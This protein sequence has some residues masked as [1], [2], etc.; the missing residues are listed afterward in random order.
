M[1]FKLIDSKRQVELPTARHDKSLI[2]SYLAES[3]ELKL[4]TESVGLLERFVVL[5]SQSGTMWVRLLYGAAVRLH[6]APYPDG[7]G[8]MIPSSPPHFAISLL[9]NGFFNLG[10]L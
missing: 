10:C 3:T 2:Y 7:F 1:G 4:N 5:M 9:Y 8:A 6:D